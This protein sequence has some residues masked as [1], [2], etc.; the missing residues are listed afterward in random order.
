MKVLVTGARSLLGRALH[1]TAPERTH[2]LGTYFKHPPGDGADRSLFYLDVRNRSDTLRTI[3]E[4]RP[5]V[6]IHC[7]CAGDPDQCEKNPELALEVNV[8]GTYNVLKA[9]SLCGARFL[10]ISSNGIFDG[11]NAPYAETDRANPLHMYGLTKLI[12]EDILGRLDPRVLIIRPNLLFGWNHEDHRPNP[13]TWTIGKLQRG[14]SIRVVDDI[15]NNPLSAVTCARAIWKA[16]EMDMT[17]I[18]HLGGATRV[19]RFELSVAVARSMGLDE[20]AIEAVPSSAFPSLTPRPVDTTFDGRRSNTLLGFE[21]PPLEQ[22]LVEVV[23]PRKSFPTLIPA[24][25]PV[26]RWPPHP[27][28]Q[29]L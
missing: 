5:D 10:F 6:V 2:F 27:S 23:R 18:L 29:P 17:G 16:V 14:E 22:D 9:A 26:P 7:A 11:R 13:L 21:P 8:H 25:P 15:F 1:E 24:E 4:V 28:P 20:S 19:S 12:A 3:E